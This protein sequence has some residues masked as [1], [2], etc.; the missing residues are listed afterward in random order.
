LK[1]H[2]RS[3]GRARK[4]GRSSLGKSIKRRCVGGRV[5]RRI[6]GHCIA[7]QPSLSA[8][9]AGV[10]A[11]AQMGERCNRTA[12]VRGSIPLSST[13][14]LLPSVRFPEYGPLGPSPAAR[15]N[16]GKSPFCRGFSNAT[17]ARIEAPIPEI[18]FAPEPPVEARIVINRE[19]VEGL[20]L[21]EMATEQC[22]ATSIFTPHTAIGQRNFDR[23]HIIIVRS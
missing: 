12:E 15:Q 19:R 22:A 10:G 13:S 16:P 1:P 2:A 18:R 17:E 4:R 6:G 20:A 7:A 9:F 3:D 11:V 8:D 23:D 5:S 21:K 14:N